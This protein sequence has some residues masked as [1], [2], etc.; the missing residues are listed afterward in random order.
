[1]LDPPWP[2]FEA[3]REHAPV[4]E[5][6]GMGAYLRTRYEDIHHIVMNPKTF[7]SE[8]EF[9]TGLSFLPSTP[10]KE[11]TLAKG[12]YRSVP[13]LGFTDPPVHKRV[14]AAVQKGFLPVGCASSRE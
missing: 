6:P 11:A 9:G 12:G 4:F 3:M 1:M 7:S 8:L 5:V 14:R 10:E 2:L 13:T